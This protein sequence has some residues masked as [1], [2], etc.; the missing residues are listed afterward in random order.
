MLRDLVTD[1]IIRSF[2]N[3]NPSLS[4][5]GKQPKY[6]PLSVKIEINGSIQYYEFSLPMILEKYV[7]FEKASFESNGS[8]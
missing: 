2:S 8:I 7:Q 5:K 3:K 1:F 4:R 6:Q